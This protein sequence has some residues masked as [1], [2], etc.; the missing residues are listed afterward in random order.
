MQNKLFI[1]YATP[2]YSNTVSDGKPDFFWAKHKK[3]LKLYIN[4]C[5]NIKSFDFSIYECK[6]ITNWKCEEWNQIER[7]LKLKKLNKQT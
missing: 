5:Y 2:K 1:V 7:G 3:Q 6:D 4:E